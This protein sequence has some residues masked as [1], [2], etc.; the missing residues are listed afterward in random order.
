MNTLT[1]YSKSTLSDLYAL[2]ASGGHFPIHEG[3]NDGKNKLVRTDASG[4]LQTG[5][6][7]TNV[8]TEN[9][10][11]C[12]RLF[13]EH[14]NDGYIRKLTPERFR[15]LITDSVYLPRLRMRNP[16]NGTSEQGGIPF[17]ISLKGAGYPVYTDP[18][19]A[20]GTNSVHVYN[21]LGNNTVTISRITDNQGSA[22]SSGYILQISTTSGEATPGR[23]GFYQTISSRKNA[24]FAQIFRAKIPTGF[25]VVNAENNMGNGYST[26]WLTDTAGTGKWEWYIRVTICGTG[27]TFSGGGHIYLSGSGAVTWYLSYCNVIDLTKGNYDGLL[28]RYSDYA[29]SAGYT[30]R[31]Y[32][33]SSNLITYPGDYSLA[34]SRFQADASNIFP[35]SSNANGV[36]TAHLHRGNYFA[37]IGLSSNG[38]MYYR[39]MAG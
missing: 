28:T 11:S 30:T 24:V 32:A 19:F 16:S 6:I 20:S 9:N 3:R 14:N 34:Y 10:L 1:G 25:S 7:N 35:V 29:T 36:I 23:G 5:Y 8:A 27:G 18:E 26:H 22:N 37:Q 12:S 17:P 13:F 38:R 31:L 15:A 39:T 21:N 2:T 33:N 4:Y